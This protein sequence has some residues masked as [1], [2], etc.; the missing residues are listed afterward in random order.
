M[1][2]TYIVTISDDTM[3]A[4]FEAGIARM[5]TTPEDFFT[6]E[7]TD[8]VRAQRTYIVENTKPVIVEPDAASI[9]VVAQE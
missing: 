6:K 7:V 3:A 8:T 9:E 4:D 1:A 2:K 5:S